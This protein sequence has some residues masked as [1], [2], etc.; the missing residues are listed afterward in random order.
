MKACG[1]CK[2]GGLVSPNMLG[3]ACSPLLLLRTRCVQF[4]FIKCSTHEGRYFFH[5]NDTDGQAAYGST[6]RWAFVCRA[7]APVCSKTSGFGMLVCMLLLLLR[8]ADLGACAAA[9]VPRQHAHVLPFPAHSWSPIACSFVIAKDLTTGKDVAYAVRTLAP[10]AG[11]PA[12]GTFTPGHSSAGPAS[13]SSTPDRFA[14]IQASGFFRTGSSDGVAAVAAAGEAAA[15][16]GEAPAAA[17]GGSAAARLQGQ[18]QQATH[19]SPHVQQGGFEGQQGQQFGRAAYEHFGQHRQ[20]SPA[21]QRDW[22]LPAREAAFA[23][24]QAERAAGGGAPGEGIGRRHSGAGLPSTGPSPAASVGGSEV[25]VPA[26]PAPMA[27]YRGT[28]AQVCLVACWLAGLFA[29]LHAGLQRHPARRIVHSQLAYS[30]LSKRAWA[31]APAI[32]AC[33]YLG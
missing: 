26:V 2:A 3:F 20:P 16:A 33:G 1:F 31:A 4:G 6:V 13:R 22:R 8:H 15:A 11:G 14:S 32:V 17:E 7:A 25:A 29:C 9:A 27:R 5:V 21:T 10:P 12:A 23:A 24:A 28:V 30:S 19:R 18:G